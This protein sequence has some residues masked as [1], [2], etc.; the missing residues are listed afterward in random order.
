M[1]EVYAEGTDEREFVDK[2]LKAG[3]PI[4]QIEVIM[5]LSKY[6]EKKPLEIQS[7]WMDAHVGV[8]QV[9]RGLTE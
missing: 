8:Q 4:A 2:S 5:V 3:V 9:F 7:A 6:L 1:P